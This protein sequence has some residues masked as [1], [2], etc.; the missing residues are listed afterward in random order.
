MLKIKGERELDKKM[1]KLEPIGLKTLNK[2]LK[3][4]N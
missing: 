2:K 1:K 4:L 3:K